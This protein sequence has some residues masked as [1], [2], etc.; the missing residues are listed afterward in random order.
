[1]ANR[2]TAARVKALMVTS[3]SDDEIEEIIPVANRMVT[4]VVG[5][6]DLTSAVMADI[7]TWLTAH[8]IAIGKER[9]TVEER[10]LDIWVVHQGTFGAGLRST[11]FGQMVLM[12]DTSGLF[13]TATKRK[14]SFA[15]IPQDPDSTTHTL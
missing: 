7:E 13:D 14:V 10:V 12:L 8:F 1:M 15:A 6:S 11:T 3:L 4:S 5:G 2:T 9:Q